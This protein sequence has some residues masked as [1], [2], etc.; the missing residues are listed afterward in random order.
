MGLLGLAAAAPSTDLLAKHPASKPDN[1]RK[2]WLGVLDQISYPMLSNLASGSLKKNMPVESLPGQED[3]RRRVTYLEAFGRTMTG[4]A[5]WLGM[6]ESTGEEKALRDKYVTLAQQAIKMAVS[7][8]SPDLMNFTTDKQPLVDAA[9]LAHALIKAPEVLWDPLDSETKKLLIA[10]MKSTRSILPYYSNWIL[11]SAMIETFLLMAGEEWDPMR[12][13]LSLK[14]FQEWYLGDGHFGDGEHFAWDYY[15]SLVIQPFLFDIA[16]VLVGKTG[17]YKEY[18]QRI[19]RIIQ[20]YADIQERL[21]APDGTYP[22]IGRSIAYRFGVFQ[23]LAHVAWRRQLPSHLPPAQ[24]RGALTAVIQKTMEAKDNFDSE[25]WLR[26][27]L[28]G[29]QPG[30]GEQ[31][32]ST[33]SLYLCTAVFLPLGLPPT[34]PFWA[35]PASEWSSRKIWNGVNLKADKSLVL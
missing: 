23:A 17:G 12:V 21:I 35:D 13:D 27:G 5:P 3:G 14:K 30:L 20:R 33:G 26:V 15:N 29:S 9:F 28:Y 25:G 18:Q 19:I 11:F 32:I 1:D 34:D 24:V 10:A 4:I 16:G 7:P 31:Y 22:A 6:T 2:Y 8:D